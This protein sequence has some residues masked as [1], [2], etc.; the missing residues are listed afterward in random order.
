MLYEL[1]S[2]ANIKGAGD[3]IQVGDAVHCTV[4]YSGYAGRRMIDTVHGTVKAIEN[5]R[6]VV[7]TPA[8][9]CELYY[10]TGQEGKTIFLD[11][12]AAELAGDGK[13]AELTQEDRE[14]SL[15]QDDFP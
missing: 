13:Q 9:K 10:S 11:Q 6:F 2:Q 7:E 3:M 14:N 12:K 5:G 8:V 4:M 15:K 1:G